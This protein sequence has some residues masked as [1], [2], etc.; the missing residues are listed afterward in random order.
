MRFQSDPERDQFVNKEE[1]AA[2]DGQEKG[3]QHH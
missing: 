2:Q 1:H 3:N